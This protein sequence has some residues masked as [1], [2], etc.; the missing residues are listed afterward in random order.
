MTN[1][2]WVVIAMFVAAATGTAHAQAPGDTPPTPP[3]RAAP[4]PVYPQE[5]PPQ[6]VPPQQQYGI[7]QTGYQVGPVDVD[8]VIAKVASEAPTIKTVAYGT[9]R[10]AR[11][12]VAFGPTIGYY[13]GFVP[14]QDDGEHALTFGLGVEVFKVPILPDSETIKALIIERIKGKIKDQ[15]FARLGGRPADPVTV[16]GLVKEIYQ[17]VRQEVLGLENRRNKHMER[18][19]FNIALEV[20]RLWRADQ[21]LPRLRVGIGIWKFT[22]GAAAGVGLGGRTKGYLGPEI[23]WHWLTNTRERS[24]VIDLFTRLDFELRD[25][26]TN[27]DQIVFGVR[28]LLDAI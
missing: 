2:R 16:E 13:G 15:L 26:D 10:R 27:G 11:R 21:W 17:D 3:D 5:A 9:L 19:R 4:E 12:A 6:P 7:P 28:F 8:Q 23:V 25:R 24:P 1:A 20:N 22:L 18:P 14:A